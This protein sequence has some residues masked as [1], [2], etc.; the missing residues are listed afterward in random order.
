MLCSKLLIPISENMPISPRSC[1]SDRDILTFDLLSQVTQTVAGWLFYFSILWD[2]CR[3][4]TSLALFT[5]GSRIIAVAADRQF[6][7]PHCSH[8]AKYLR[9]KDDPLCNSHSKLALRLLKWRDGTHHDDDI[10]VF[11]MV[12]P[13]VSGRGGALSF[14]IHFYVLEY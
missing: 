1:R 12:F 5:Q 10:C 9:L 2:L 8:R 7:A 11:F 14:S 4:L 13:Q 6:S 3:H